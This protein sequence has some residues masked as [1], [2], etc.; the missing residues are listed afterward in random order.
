[1]KGRLGD[2]RGAVLRVVDFLE[3]QGTVARNALCR[4]LVELVLCCRALG[5]IGDPAAVPT[6]TGLLEKHGKDSH[7]SDRYC[8]KAAA[9]AL[10][11]IGAE[12]VQPLVRLLGSEHAETRKFAAYALGKIGDRTAFPALLE[13]VKSHRGPVREAAGRALLQIDR[14]RAAE[15]IKP[16]SL[17]PTEDPKTGFSSFKI[18]RTLDMIKHYCGSVDHLG[19][20]SEYRL[21]INLYEYLEEEIDHFFREDGSFGEYFN[22]LSDDYDFFVRRGLP[23]ELIDELAGISN[24]FLLCLCG[25]NLRWGYVYSL[26]KRVFEIEDH[27]GWHFKIRDIICVYCENCKRFAGFAKDVDDAHPGHKDFYKFY[28]P[29]FPKPSEL[30]DRKKL[31]EK[32]PILI[33]W[34]R[35]EYQ[36]YDYV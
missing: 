12:A 22:P 25:E 8:L 7:P 17:T 1:M 16:D 15:I 13:A 9:D 18:K 24:H 35:N 29:R 11:G 19:P 33:E 23:Q 10:V 34:K 36:T 26:S 2:M 20:P 14:E 5:I 28:L 31:E 30:V 21:S 27:E 32:K 6:L 4:D 3:N